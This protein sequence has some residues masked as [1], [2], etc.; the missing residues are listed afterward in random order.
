MYGKNGKRIGIAAQANII[1][2]WRKPMKITQK[3]CI[4]IE[5]VTRNKDEK[6]QDFFKRVNECLEN[7]NVIDVRFERVNVGFIVDDF[8]IG[9][10][11]ITHKEIIKK[12]K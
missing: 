6:V 10:A 1:R 2:T 5:Y 8:R 3:Q 9:L 11:I 7:L 12:I 4:Q